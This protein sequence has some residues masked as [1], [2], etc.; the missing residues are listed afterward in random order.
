M[1]NI[2]TWDTDG[3]GIC[4]DSIKAIDITVILGSE[5]KS[6]FLA[7]DRGYPLV[8]RLGNGCGNRGTD[9]QVAP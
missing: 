3:A 6:K 2:G 7:R 5:L 4:Q 1:M 9:F 8:A